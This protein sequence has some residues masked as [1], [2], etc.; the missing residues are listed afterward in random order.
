[1][2]LSSFSISYF[3]APLVE[4]QPRVTLVWVS[5]VSRKFDG[6]GGGKPSIRHIL[7]GLVQYPQL[8]VPLHAWTRNLYVPG[9]D[10][11]YVWLRAEAP[12]TCALP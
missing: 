8:S 5:R 4:L 1:M 10:T 2:L 3:A 6:A 9:F 12:F 11:V 7:G